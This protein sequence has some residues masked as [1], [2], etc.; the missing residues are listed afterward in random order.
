MEF[1]CIVMRARNDMP[2]MADTLGMLARQDV[3]H[4]LI[5]L[6]NAS[7]DGTR[8]VAERH[9]ARVIHVPEGE[10]VPGRVL[11]LGME[12]TNGDIVVFLNSDCTP[13]HP[14]WL[15]R[16]LNAFDRPRVAAVFGRQE[17]RP[18]CHPLWAR[19]IEEMYGDGARQDR[20]RHCFSMAASAIRR[21][22]WQEMRFNEDLR[23][24]EDIDWTWRARSRG[25]TIRYVAD[26]RVLHSHEYSTTQL[27]RRQYGEAHAEARIFTWSA[28]QRSFLRYAL[29]PYG[30]QVLADIR[31]CLSQGRVDAAAAAPLLR[32]VGVAA[33][34]QGLRDGLREEHVRALCTTRQC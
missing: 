18:G 15:R 31:Y 13:T 32:M 21:E 34:W 1:P 7:R 30:R 3:P 23:Y 29:L 20:W 28:W 17:P 19:D 5:V 8:E 24:S 10:Y 11:N 26:A 9:G 27:Y 6:D 22:V 4:R 33:R 25:Y 16:L 2:V 14:E 12:N